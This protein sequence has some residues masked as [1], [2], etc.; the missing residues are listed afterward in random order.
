MQI[1]IIYSPKYSWG[2]VILQTLR[3]RDRTLQ[4]LRN[5]ETVWRLHT[6]VICVTCHNICCRN[7]QS[8]KDAR[9]LYQENK[10]W[11]NLWFSRIIQEFW[12]SI[13]LIKIA[14][15][16]Y[17]LVLFTPLCQRKKSSYLSLSV[18]L[19]TKVLVCLSDFF[20]LFT[21]QTMSILH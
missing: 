21:C 16:F 20:D 13:G 15:V 5:T 9:G 6:K 1:A 7:W 17:K 8:G 11:P 12:V 14:R 19:L 2:S 18:S 3:K 10:T 4:S